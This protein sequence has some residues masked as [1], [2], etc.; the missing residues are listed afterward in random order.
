MIQEGLLDEARNLYDLHIK[1]KAVMTPI[2]LRN[3][4]DISMEKFLWMRLFRILKRIVDVMRKG[5][6]LGLIIK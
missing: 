6:T 4:L 5:S 1:T 3:F 2:G